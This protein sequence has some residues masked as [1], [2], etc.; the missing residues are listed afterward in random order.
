M[1]DASTGWSKGIYAVWELTL[2]CDLS[3][4]HCGSRAG[5]PR[6][7]ELSTDEAL[8][9]VRQL[10]EIEVYEVTLIGGEAYLR[11]DWDVIARAI[12]DAKMYCTMTTGGRGMNPDRARRV[13]DSGIDSVSVSIDGMREAHDRQRGVK[14]SFDAALAAVSNLRAAGV[15]VSINTQINRVSRPDLDAI[16]DLLI[17]HKVHSWQF[18]LTVPMGRAADR[19][20]WLL[21]PYE[22]NALY[23]HI[24]RLLDRLD[25]AKIR[26][27]PGNN[28]GYYG[29]L[30]DRFR[31]GG[32]GGHW[33][34]CRASEKTLG[35][36]ADGT[37]KGCPSLPTTPYAGGNLRDA[38]LRD[39]LDRAPPITALR[40]R[41]VDDLW[42]YCRGCYYAD[43]CRAGCTWTA[44][45]LLG[46]SG[47]NPYCHHRSLDLARRGLRERLIH[48]E[49]APG[50][51]FDNGRF[52]LAL[53]PIDAPIPDSIESRVPAAIEGNGAP[54]RL[55]LAP[56]RE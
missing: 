40:E 49:A 13:K 4:A 27:W 48:A 33:S 6:A 32:V 52:D 23:E 15:A 42:G 55:P 7:D 5:K 37:L 36:E 53:E 31:G 50:L 22:L 46:R 45:V 35:I 29:P 47:N 56:A 19:P 34:G 17:E 3:C 21:Q 43:V 44:H 54:R 38:R 41:T 8:E 51:P 25:A 11:E 1:T 18:Q 2:R 16:V 28:I 26:P 9:V 14:G 30:E 39:L 24:A 20:D 10:A 12:A